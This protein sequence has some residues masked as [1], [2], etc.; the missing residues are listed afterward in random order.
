MGAGLCKECN[1]TAL[2]I[3]YKPVCKSCTIQ[4]ISEYIQELRAELGKIKTKKI[5]WSV[6]LAIG[7]VIGAF[8][9]FQEETLEITDFLL[10]FIVWGC[11][12]FWERRKRHLEYQNNQ[13]TVSAVRQGVFEG[14]MYKDG[15]ILFY[16]FGQI[17]TKAVIFITRG[18]FFPIFYA[19]FMLTG[20]RKL[21][22]ELKSAE[23]NVENL[24]KEA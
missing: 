13:S 14:Q 23:E 24:S 2:K 8:I 4:S 10:V 20:E 12:G 15:S 19:I 7:L 6:I 16:W 11:A 17:L 5:I 1:E 22:A 3:D 9:A 18:L 21:A